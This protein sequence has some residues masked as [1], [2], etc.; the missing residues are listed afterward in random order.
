AE[1]AAIPKPPGARK[2]PINTAT[3]I[4]AGMS[5][6]LNITNNVVAMVRAITV[7]VKVR[8]GRTSSEPPAVTA[9]AALT[10]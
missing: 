7:P 9:V 5:T 2:P 3:A 6:G 4:A 10:I 8:P 1:S